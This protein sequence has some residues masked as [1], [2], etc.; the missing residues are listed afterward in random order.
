V[1]NTVTIQIQDSGGS[2]T[3]DPP[4]ATV[5]QGHSIQW[6]SSC[7]YSVTLTPQGCPG[8]GNPKWPWGSSD[9]VS[10]PENGP[11]QKHH[12]PG[13]APKGSYTYSASVSG[14]SQETSS[15]AL[16]PGNPEIVVSDGGGG[17][18]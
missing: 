14:K 4:P 18:G 15:G 8:S 5:K 17:I 7:N 2:P 16:A 6:T 12:V 3:I 11:S 1:S 10:V 13:S 9:P